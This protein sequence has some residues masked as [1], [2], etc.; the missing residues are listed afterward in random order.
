VEDIS[1]IS[2]DRRIPT[3]DH[4]VPIAADAASDRMLSKEQGAKATSSSTV[5][6]STEKIDKIIDLVGEL[7][8]AQTMILAALDSDRA[9]SRARLR[10]AAEAV[11]RN[12][13]ELQEQVMGVRMVPVGTV[14][15]RFPR[16][17]RDLAARFGKTI[18]LHIEGENTEIDRGAVVDGTIAGIASR[19]ASSRC[20]PL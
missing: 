18:T 7:V 8:I 16:V 20:E 19:A 2:I 15:R 5:R 3:G 4:A 11:G 1:K 13:R 14:F 10:D 17:V 9:D 12:T 6:V